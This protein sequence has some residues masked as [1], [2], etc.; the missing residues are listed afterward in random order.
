MPS[1][2][3]TRTFGSPTNRKKFTL[4]MWVKLSGRGSG[5]NN[6]LLVC[7]TSGG[8]EATISFGNDALTWTE[9]KP[10]SGTVAYSN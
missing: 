7:G 5:N 6:A 10:G 4:S 8:D 3:L 2:Y 9:Y 1:T